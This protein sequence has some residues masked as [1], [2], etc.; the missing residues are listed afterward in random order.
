MADRKITSLP[1]TGRRWIGQSLSG[2]FNSRLWIALLTQILTAICR[3]YVLQVSDRLVTA[4]ARIHDQ[5]A[6]K[7]VICRSRDALVCVGYTGL[8]YLDGIP[9]DQWIAQSFRGAPLVGGIAFDQSRTR[10]NKADIGLLTK[11]L[12]HELQKVVSSLDP[13]RS[14]YPLALNI[15]GWQWY[16]GKPVVRPITVEIVKLED[17]DK[18]YVSRKP[19]NWLQTLSLQVF[20]TG[21]HV[22]R[23][24]GLRKGLIDRLNAVGKGALTAP[25]LVENAFA[26]TIREASAKIP[27]VG[28]DLMTVLMPSSPIG[29]RVT[30]SAA[31]PHQIAYAP[32]IIGQTIA[33][34]PSACTVGF[35]ADLGVPVEVVAPDDGLPGYIEG[36]ARPPSR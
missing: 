34:G 36:Q 22:S 28:A 16:K 24:I 13:K 11:G 32:W 8:A 2:V 14:K 6:P 4:G 9:T 30:F 17:S 26:T 3:N 18:I 12:V 23:D 31:A 5:L 29:A 19:R 35:I 33:I 10:P 1:L 27:S 7:T 15:S 25:A 21:G 20:D